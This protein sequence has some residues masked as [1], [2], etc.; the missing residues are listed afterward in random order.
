MPLSQ[1][2]KIICFLN[3]LFFSI[4]MKITF[5]KLLQ[6]VGELRALSIILKFKLSKLI[7][8]CLKI[9]LIKTI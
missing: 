8:C 2:L 6:L 9:F 7:A 4:I 3:K 1:I 5:I